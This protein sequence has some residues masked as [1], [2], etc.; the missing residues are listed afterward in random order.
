LNIFIAE[1][2]AKIAPYQK[3]YR[4]WWLVLP[5]HIG[6]DLDANERQIIGEHVNLLTFSRVVLIHPRDP[7]KAL[8]L[9]R[10]ATGHRT[11]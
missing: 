4:E 1:K 3:R 6:P 10:Q 11:A 8:V 5:D 9:T 7:T 2:A